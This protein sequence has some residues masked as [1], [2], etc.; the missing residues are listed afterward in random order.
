VAAEMTEFM[1]GAGPPP[2]RI[3]SFTVLH[4][5]TSACCCSDGAVLLHNDGCLIMLRNV[6]VTFIDPPEPA[7]YFRH[8]DKKVSFLIAQRSLP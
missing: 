4:P 6:N 7:A 1:P 2:H 5:S 3:P 8:K